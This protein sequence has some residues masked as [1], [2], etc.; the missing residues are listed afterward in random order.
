MSWIRRHLT[1]VLTSL[2][3]IGLLA[4]A[5]VYA[6]SGYM[7][8]KRAF[9]ELNDALVE[10][11]RLFEM[12]PHPGTEKINN[13]QIA[14]EHQKQLRDFLEKAGARFVRV[15]PIPDSSQITTEEFA[16]QLN[17]TIDKLQHDAVASGVALPPKYNFTF[18][19]IKRRV[20]FSTNSLPVLA[21]QLGE[22]K[23]ICDILLRARIH[24]LDNL[25]RERVCVED[26]PE[27][28]PSDYLDQQSITNE[29]AVLTPYEITFRCFSSEFA[30][31]LGGFAS[32]PHCFLISHIDVGPV[33]AAVPEGFYSPEGYAP[34]ITPGYP[35]RA[36]IPE[37][38]YRPM[39]PGY[40]GP[41]YERGPYARGPETGVTAPMP[42]PGTGRAGLQPVLDE[43]LFRVVLRVYVVKLNLPK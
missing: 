39:P 4:A 17:R 23:A 31:V 21:V 6:L 19:S 34:S 33:A 7:A 24:S 2:L 12:D 14:R 40:A 16:S 38:T 10:L 18:E 27:T 5:C 29:L 36:M 9:R 22:V 13:I 3:T 30:G 37:E 43:T 11:K 8:N 32:S 26:S 1:F 15:P 28:V 25:R 20:T 42:A 35:G 41:F